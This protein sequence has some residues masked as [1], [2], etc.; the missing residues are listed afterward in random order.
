MILDAIPG[1]KRKFTRQRRD[2]PEPRAF[3]EIAAGLVA[4]LAERA[5]PVVH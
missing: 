5:G 1:R 3:G 2:R 4:R